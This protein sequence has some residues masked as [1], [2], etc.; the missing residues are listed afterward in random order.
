MIFSPNR[1]QRSP[2]IVLISLWAIAIVGGF[3]MLAKHENTPGDVGSTAETWI[4][5]APIERAA[6]RATLIMFVHPRCPCVHAGLVELDRLISKCGNGVLVN[7]IVYQPAE[8]DSAWSS[9]TA[10]LPIPRAA[11]LR[12]IQDPAGRLA[13]TFGVET[14]GDCLLYSPDGRLLFHGG[15]TASRG[16]AGDSPQLET[17]AE[18]IATRNEPLLTVMPVFGCPLFESG[19]NLAGRE[20]R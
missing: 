10:R 7:V 15:I 4:A 2:A 16:H 11:N 20:P 5:G 1:T 14:S 12:T 19:T 3:M 17:L 13:A 8:P 6:D 18:L 9:A